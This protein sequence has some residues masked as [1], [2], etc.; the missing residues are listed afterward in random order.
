MKKDLLL[1]AVG[2]CLDRG[3]SCIDN[4]Q[5]VKRLQYIPAGC[6]FFSKN[7]QYPQL[8]TKKKNTSS[9]KELHL[10]YKRTCFT[11]QKSMFY[12]ASVV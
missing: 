3:I 6:W 4:Q 11:G 2:C 5:S 10:L 12:K 7:S 8:L 1:D 9:T